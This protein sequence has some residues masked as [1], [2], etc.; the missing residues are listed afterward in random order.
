M[1]QK[2]KLKLLNSVLQDQLVIVLMHFPRRLSS[3][4]NFPVERLGDQ[5]GGKFEELAQEFRFP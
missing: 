5:L 4:L 2:T 3:S 1:R